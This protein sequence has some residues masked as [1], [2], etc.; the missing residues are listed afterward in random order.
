MRTFISSSPEVSV[1]IPVFNAEK[2]LPECLD[3][4]KNQSFHNFEALLIDDCS[5]DKSQKICRSYVSNDPRFQLLIHLENKGP[6]AARNTALDIARGKTVFFL[7]ADDLLTPNALSVL[8]NRFEMFSSDICC[9]TFEYFNS[10]EKINHPF[11]FFSDEKI[12]DVSG[13]HSEMQKHMNTPNKE[14]IFAYAWG[15]LFKR[16]IIEKYHIRF[17]ESMKTFEDLKF[18]YQFAAVSEKM[19]FVPELIYNY[20]IHEVSDSLSMSVSPKHERLMDL[21]LFYKETLNFSDSIEISHYAA[22]N[23][24]INLLIIH[25]VRHCVKLNFSNF[26]FLYRQVK[27]VIHQDG[28]TDALNNYDSTPPGRSKLMPF[29]MRYKLV[30]PLLLLGKY[31]AWKRYKKGK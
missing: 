19:S 31:K 6:A 15:K 9:G 4:L 8:Y 13:I 3:S 21:F 7:D 26:K 2:Y 5:T 28:F 27:K 22:D 29:F 14:F 30:V 16:D 20:R 24:M 17:C 23:C 25:I 10:S 11:T 18:I 1:I 12:W